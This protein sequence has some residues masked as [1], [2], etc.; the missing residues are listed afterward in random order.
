MSRLYSSCFIELHHTN[1]VT[2][3]DIEVQCVDKADSDID[4]S[5]VVIYDQAP[6]NIG[7]PIGL[8]NEINDQVSSS[9]SSFAL[10]R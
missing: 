7:E 2:A 3:L 1:I 9:S 5:V 8:K 6:I 10:V 4:H